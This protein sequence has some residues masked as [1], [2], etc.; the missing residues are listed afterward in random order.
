MHQIRQ[1]VRTYTV[2]IQKIAQK[3]KFKKFILDSSNYFNLSQIQHLVKVN[4]EVYQKKMKTIL[5]IK[6][7]MQPRRLDPEQIEQQLSKNV[8]VPI[9]KGSAF[10]NYKIQVIKD[11]C[12]R[13]SEVLENSI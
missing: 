4:H 9:P 10:E 12:Q 1:M 7:Q 8:S 13:R 6:N 2:K 5:R 11:D 3:D